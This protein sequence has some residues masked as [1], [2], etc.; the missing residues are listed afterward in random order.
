MAGGESFPASRW[1][2][3]LATNGGGCLHGPHR[4]ILVGSAAPYPVTKGLLMKL[5][6]RTF[7]VIRG[8][9]LFTSMVGWLHLLGMIK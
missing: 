9:T 2:L 6:K 3:A 1:L 4:R 5:I 7:L 8:V